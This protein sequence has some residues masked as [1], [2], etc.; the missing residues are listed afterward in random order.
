MPKYRARRNAVSAVMPRRPR[1]IS[2]IR[3]GITPT[4]FASAVADNPTHTIAVGKPL[5]VLAPKA[6]N[7]LTR[8]IAFR[9]A[10]R[11]RLTAGADTCS[12]RLE[13]HSCPGSRR[14]AAGPGPPSRIYEYAVAG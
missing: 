11:N 2:L 3:A 4:A 10:E 5:S 1:T 7:H 14:H 13:P 6:P 8:Y 9:Y 12:P